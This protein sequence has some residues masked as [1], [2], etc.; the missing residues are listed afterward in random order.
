M[1][2]TNI[3]SITLPVSSF[4]LS[5]CSVIQH[6]VCII[7]NSWRMDRAATPVCPPL[8]VRECECVCAQVSALPPATCSNV[9]LVFVNWNNSYVPRIPRIIWI[10]LTMQIWICLVSLWAGCSASRVKKINKFNTAVFRLW[11]LVHF[12]L[13]TSHSNIVNDVTSAVMYIFCL[14]SSS[15][16]SL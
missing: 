1:L 2:Q 14:F 15:Y 9:P 8:C 10:W 11:Y 7:P 3:L 4:R 16:Y 13:V 5:V 12:Q 6:L